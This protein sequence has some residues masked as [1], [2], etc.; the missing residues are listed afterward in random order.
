LSLYD[1]Q[2]K[3]VLLLC[4]HTMW[5]PRS[6][7]GRLQYRDTIL[8]YKPATQSLLGAVLHIRKPKEAQQK[9]TQLGLLPTEQ[10]ELCVVHC[11]EHFLKETLIYRSTLPEDH[12]LLLTYLNNP[13]ETP[14]TS[15]QPKTAATWVK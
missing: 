2:Q 1:L 8:R 11:L 10:L 5:R 4:L 15:I 3:L 12:S 14:P 6:D 9:T 7:I 13:E